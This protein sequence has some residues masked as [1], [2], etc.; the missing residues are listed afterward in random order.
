LII[1]FGVIAYHRG[2]GRFLAPISINGAG[3]PGSS[4]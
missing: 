4:I 1:L 3:A 2:V